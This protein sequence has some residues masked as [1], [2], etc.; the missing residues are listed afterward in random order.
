MCY[1]LNKTHS[2]GTTSMKTITEVK[3]ET[4]IVGEYDVIVAGG[5][6]AGFSAAVVA[7]REGAKVC[8]VEQCGGV[9]GVATS[10]MMS[11]WTGNTKGG[12]YEEILL[13]STGAGK[14]NLIDPEK[15]H[16]TL[17]EMLLE[18]GVEIRLY[19]F[20]VAPVMEGDKVC[21]LITESK[22][23][24]QALLCNVLIDA[25]GDGDIAARAGAEFQLGRESDSAMQPMTQMFK[26][27]GVDYSKAIFPGSFESKVDVPAGEI[28]ALA[29]EKLPH[30][31]GHV[32]LYQTAHPG[33][34]TCNMTNVINVDGTKAED[35]TKAQIV[36]RKQIP[37]IVDFLRKYAP[38]YENCYLI[39]AAAQ[40]G[41]RE[42]RHFIGLSTIT[43][44]DIM[45]A[46]VFPDWVVTKAHFNF[47]IHNIKGAGLD[48]HGVQHHFKQ[49]E[50][51]TIPYGCLVP[52]RIKG[53]LLAGR[54][55]SGTH[56]AHSNFRVMPICA[57]IG[58]AAGT[59]AAMAAARGVEPRDL[60]VADIQASLKRQGVTE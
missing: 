30:P 7:A 23:G 20:A 49:P 35:L 56:K 54:L 28:Q 33:V 25:S 57:N 53:L 51:Y 26:V 16:G 3:K 52:K 45:A 29:H 34:V 58:Q 44:H 5:G 40:I 47:D 48:E 13:R 60:P 21:G 22:T 17:L 37:L 32:L 39:S 6:P 4:P 31:A 27:A 10:G 42:T 36:C 46:R 19:T 50:G 59:A 8:L 55:I 11:H 18:A 9:G 38:G 43:E 24:R 15:L 1:G 2:I 41:V 12:F 14:S